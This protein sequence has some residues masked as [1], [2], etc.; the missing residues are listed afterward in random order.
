[1]GY[2]RSKKARYAAPA[3][4][5]AAVGVG[6][7]VPTLSGAAATPNL[8]A[9][10]AQQVL[11]DVLAAK[12]APQL[13]GTLQ[14][15]A[16]LGLSDLS[17]LEAGAGQTGASGNG[18]DPLSLLSGNF[19]LKLWLGA[20]AEHISL[21]EP[22]AQ[23]VDVVRNHNQL[24]LWDSSTQK[25]THIIGPAR[26]L[27]AASGDSSGMSTAT[28]ASSLTPMQVASKLLSHVGPNTSVT[29]GA[30]LFVAG[31]PAY[32]LVIGPKATAGSTIRDIEIAVGAEGALKG[33]P[34]QVAVFANGQAAPALELGFTSLS[35]GAPPASELTFTPPP[36]SHVTTHDLSGASERLARAGAKPAGARP[37]GT[38]AVPPLAQTAPL[39]QPASPSKTGVV[40][41]GPNGPGATTTSGKG[42]A[43]VVS[44]PAG[45]ALGSA[46]TGPLSAVT[47]VV[48]VG[49]QQGRLFSTELLNVL[50]MPNGR[51]YA[52][53]ATPS[54]LEAAAAS[55]SS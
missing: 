36:G 12:G 44:G 55:A 39:S 1:M 48:N 49:G 34:L 24:W 3:V 38:R 40:A 8:P 53:L 9:Q 41:L 16:N 18:F 54:V 15:T 6:A 42:W 32:Q 31:Q 19:Q 30:P 47:T 13:S 50:L 11:A 37:A 45:Q 27:K 43:T 20:H 23:E 46:E 21:I 17:S 2:L 7:A 29:S 4:V 26:A 14:W 52:G 10:T 33:V 22:D 51:F 35:V 25:V 28:S 5:L